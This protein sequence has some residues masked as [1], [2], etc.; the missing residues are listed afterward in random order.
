LGV[1]ISVLRI[2]EHATIAELA[3]HLQ[4]SQVY[5]TTIREAYDHAQ[6]RRRMATSPTAFDVAI[7]GM[8]GRFPGARNL[9]ELWKNLCDGRESVTT[10]TREELDPLVPKQDREDPSYVPARGVLE[11][12]DRFDAAFFGITPNEAELM[13]PQLRLFMEVAWEAFENAGYVGE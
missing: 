4:G 8:A 13:A 1:E 3:R 2:F 5:A 10:F 9:D 7:V 6:A 12:I 11:D